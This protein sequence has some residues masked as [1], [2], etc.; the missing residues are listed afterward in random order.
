LYNSFQS[1]EGSEGDD[2]N[3]AP[4]LWESQEDCEK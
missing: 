1:E 2:G 4:V 3:D